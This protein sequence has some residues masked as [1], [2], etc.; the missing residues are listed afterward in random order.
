MQNILTSVLLLT[1]VLPPL[2]KSLQQSSAPDARGT[3]AVTSAV[4]QASTTTKV[5]GLNFS[6]YID[7]Q[8]PNINPQ[9]SADQVLSRMQIVAPFT[10][11]VR[12]FSST[13]GLEN[14]PP[15]AR[16]LGLNV[17]AGAWISSNLTQNSA[18][19][20]NLI[21]AANAGQVNIAII[22]SEVLLRGDVSEA[23][24]IAYM[25]QVRAAI[26][27]NIPVTTAD[28]FDLLLRHPNVIAASDVIMG[29]F[30]P[31][32]QGV[33]NSNA[34][35][36][37]ISSYQQLVTAANGKTVWIS[38]SGWPSGGNSVGAAV[39]SPDNENQFFL[40]FTSW[41]AANNVPYFYFDAFN[42][43]WKANHGEG[44]QGAFWGVWD[45][46]GILKPGMNAVF[47]GQ[48]AATNCSV[49]PGQAGDPTIYLT[50]VP[51]LG[52]LTDS[53][54]GQVLHVATSSASVAIY[55]KVGA[56]WWTKPTF[57]QPLTFIQP[58]GTWSAPIVTGGSD[59]AATDIA[60]FVVPKGY[61][62]PQ[63]GGALAL[64]ADLYRNSL[65]S[66]QI[67]RTQNFI[68]G[69]VTDGSGNPLAGINL[70]LSGSNTA[71]TQSAPDGRYSFPNLSGSG[72]WT[73]TPASESFSFSPA[74]QTVT[75]LNGNQGVNFTGSAV[76]TGPHPSVYIDTPSV[77]TV[78]TGTVTIYGWAIDNTSA[79]GSAI[80][81]SSVQVLVDGVKAGNA[82]YGVSRPDVCNAFPG[83]SGCPNVGFFFN[84]N[85]SQLS[86]GPHI[87]TVQA[88]DTDAAPDTGSA[89]LL[90]VAAGLRPTIYIDTPASNATVSGIVTVYGWA[91]D[92]ISAVGSAIDPAS[93]QVL[94]DGVQNGNA[95][96]G[97]IRQDVCN[98]FP[99]RPGCPNVGFS[100][101]LD[102]TKL[103]PGPRIITVTAGDTD[104][105]QPDRG[106]T[107]VSVT[108][109]PVS[110]S[111]FI[112]TPSSGATVSGVVPIYG[113]ALDNTL[114]T[115]TGIN[116]V[117]ILVDGKNQ[118]L[119]TYGVPRPDV[120]N[121]FP[122]R[123]GCPNVG[124]I[125]HLDTSALAAGSHVITVL[126]TDTDGTLPDTGT[127]TVQLVIAH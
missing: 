124:F 10:Q 98:A 125:F 116:S 67:T 122:G 81:S 82:T 96:Y 5:F 60:A 42:E 99:G 19:I 117:Q 121:A 102:T 97:I 110:P 70:F 109:V 87:V 69:R 47:N 17:A 39:P 93:L 58:D 86:P 120:C 34:M 105:P 108:V 3:T 61:T 41:A 123:I 32:W 36:S 72:P 25:N 53:L 43:S 101:Q 30:Y 113:W 6:P 1:M 75:G 78:V 31:Y 119:A 24:L 11:W 27:A 91:I 73:I 49:V 64:P 7:G 65:A 26:P 37:L 15:T 8:D 68:S 56:G 126:A 2:G 9:V 90:L 38:E 77:G 89:S 28:T 103:A 33:S 127:A 74:S 44:P 112:D 106:S 55:I 50:Y 22:G 51:P 111:V 76:A 52:N 13:T 63:L 29:N 54:E 62:P 45:Q 88:T 66:V 35:C 115:G 59:Q 92:N 12:S 4:N 118:G 20:N 40:Q 16:S 94:V 80:N 46:N 107:S 100:F 104:S 23:Q 57:A 71:G 84:L 95:A 85:A 18:E 21:T 48:T 114:I 14:I 83:R 79:V